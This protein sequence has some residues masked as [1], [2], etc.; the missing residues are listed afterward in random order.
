M[1]QRVVIKF[2]AKLGTTIIKNEILKQVYGDES[3]LGTCFFSSIKNFART[4]NQR[5]KS[6]TEDLDGSHV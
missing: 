5:R 4:G 6:Y 2:Y 3:L 1:E